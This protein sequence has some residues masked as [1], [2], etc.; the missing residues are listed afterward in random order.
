M[1]IERAKAHLKNKGYLDRVIEPE[2]GTFTVEDAARALGCEPANIAK[3]MSFYAPDN[4]KTIL[5]V[6]AGD[7]KID[8]RKFRDALGVKPHMLKPD[9]VEPRIGHAPGGVCAFGINNGVSVYCDVS[10]KRFDF[11]Y[12]AAGNDHSGVKLNCEELYDA[13]DAKDWVDVC[14][15]WE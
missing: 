1:S 14:K 9:E 4:E 5:I 2:A 13:C 15:G 7:A 3:T 11:V 10:L 12:P 8:N 6:A